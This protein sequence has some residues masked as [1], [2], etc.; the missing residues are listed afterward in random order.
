MLDLIILQTGNMHCSNPL[1][2]TELSTLWEP[3]MHVNP[4]SQKAFAS[5]VCILEVI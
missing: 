1:L 5:L 2:F 3:C 4:E